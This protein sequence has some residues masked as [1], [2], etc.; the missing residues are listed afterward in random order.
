MIRTEQAMLHKQT[1]KKANLY[2]LRKWKSK[3][4]PWLL[5]LII[6]QSNAIIIIVGVGGYLV[7]KTTSQLL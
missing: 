5:L 7:M 6:L 4:Y 3:I 1:K 2:E